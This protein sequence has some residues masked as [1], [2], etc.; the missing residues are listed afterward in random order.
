MS[1]YGIDLGTTYSC[2]AKLDNYGNPIVIHNND[3]GT[4]TLASAIY[5]EN[6]QNIIVG[7]VA[8]EYAETDGVNVVQFI[9]RE[10]GKDLPP[11]CI[12][13]KSYTPTVLSAYILKRLKEMAEQQG[14][15]VKDVVI[16]IP[17]Y[18]GFKERNQTLNAGEMA[19][20]NV[21]NLINEP[22]AAA[23]NYCYRLYQEDM[24]VLVYDLGGGTFDVSLVHM[25]LNDHRQMEIITTGGNDQLGGKDWD[26]KLFEI[27]QEHVMAEVGYISQLD[28]DDIQAI[29]AKVEIAKKKLSSAIK[30]DIR[31]RIQGQ[32]IKVTITRQEFEEATKAL[33]NQTMTYVDNTLAKAKDIK[34]D[35]VL[36]V[37]GSTY[38]PMIKNAVEKRFPGIVQQEDPD[39]AV[40][41]GAAIY[42]NMMK[43]EQTATKQSFHFFKKKSN[44][45]ISATVDMIVNDVSPRSFGIG[46]NYPEGY[47]IDNIVKEGQ[48]MNK[49][50]ERYYAT[51]YD[52]QTGMRFQVFENRSLDDKTFPCC[53]IGSNGQDIPVYTDPALEVKK[54]GDFSMSLNG[55]DPKGTNVKCEFIVKASG[56]YITVTSVTDKHY[57]TDAFIT[58]EN[59]YSASDIKKTQKEIDSITVMSD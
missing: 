40:A 44:D 16:T 7:E 5:F 51:I 18:F 43:Q 17:A 48:E 45:E 49:V 1:V 57:S 10:I 55:K 34:I 13:G 19:G 4:D 59:S 9:K 53:F 12:H 6:S 27:I 26:D 15:N 25:A 33:V 52:N 56:I 50:Y 46:V 31:L 32:M 29:R 35:K 54:L 28:V 37:G 8:K 47:R 41:K 38:M 14:E 42:A 21:L 11:H 36:L 24:N 22:T 39:R 20:L 30:T 2:I 58:Y 3:D 23:L